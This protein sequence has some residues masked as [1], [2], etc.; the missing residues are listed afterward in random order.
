MK[1]KVKQYLLDHHPVTLNRLTAISPMRKWGAKK[2]T[3]AAM[4]YS[5]YNSDMAEGTTFTDFPVGFYL[6]ALTEHGHRTAIEI[7]SF[8]GGRIATVKKC[9]PDIVAYGLDIGG[10]YT[11]PFDH[12]GV[13]FEKFDTGFFRRSFDAPLVLAHCTL[14]YVPPDDLAKFLDCLREQKLP[15]AFCEPVP[16]HRYDQLMRRS[17]I[18]HYHPYPSLFHHAG[19]DLIETN[20]QSATFHSF[21]LNMG[22]YTYTNYATPR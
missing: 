2:R 15:I 19:F 16:A 18:A 21:S 8:G 1:R 10:R 12:A 14:N 13:H 20:Y 3:D 9:L 22:E 11:Q 5:Q 17:E 6:R 7:G 4:D